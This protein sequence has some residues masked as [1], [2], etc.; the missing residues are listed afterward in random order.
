[1]TGEP[2]R[3]S[4]SPQAAESLDDLAVRIRAEFTAVRKA[5]GLTIDHAMIAG[6]LL[7]DAQKRVSISWKKWLIGNRLAVSTAFLYQRLA[8]H[9]SVIEAAMASN[10]DFGIADARRLTTTPKPR[11]ASEKPD[12]V[13]AVERATD[14]EITEALRAM[15]FLKFLRVMPPGWRRQLEMRLQRHTGPAENVELKATEIL[16]RALS[17]IAIGTDTSPAAHTANEMEAMN[18]LRGLLAWA[19]NR[20]LS[21][22][23]IAIVQ[24]DA[25]H[26]SRRAA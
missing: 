1:M 24:S 22:N 17:L 2:N 20:K 25:K 12:L 14:T 6:D 4:P 10:P 23:D 9:R 11:P 21:V 7:N 16:R 15:T 19:A 26:A 5:V 18:A 3:S 13:K 8:R